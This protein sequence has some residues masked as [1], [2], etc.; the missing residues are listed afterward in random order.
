MSHYTTELRFVCETAANQ[1]ASGGYDDID[2]IIAAARTNIFSFNYPIFDAAYRET[3]ET[4]ILRRYYFREI[5]FETVGL[6]RHYLQMRMNEIMPYYN[7]LYS[8]ELLTFNP[9]YDTDLQTTGDKNSAGTSRKD[10][11]NNGTVSDSMTGNVTDTDSTRSTESRTSETQ[12]EGSEAVAAASGDKSSASDLESRNGSETV[13]AGKTANGTLT[14]SGTDSVDNTGTDTRTIERDDTNSHWDLYSDT[15]Q[16]G[17]DGVQSESTPYLTNARHV[18]DDSTGSETTDTLVHG[19]STDTI[20][21]HVETTVNRENESSAASKQEENRT[22]RES[23][24]EHTESTSRQNSVSE[25]STE[26]NAANSDTQHIKGYDTT[27]AR[28]ST[29]TSSE[30]GSTA[31]QSDY[32]EHVLGKSAGSGSYSKLLREFRETF[33]NIDMMVIDDLSDLFMQ[34]W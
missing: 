29:G 3:L 1:T 4:K 33:L 21:G 12:T 31:E 20:Y 8:S 26:E 23:E 14:H 18:I 7:K 6:F 2:S 34:V 28:T 22:D 5:G 11:S 10:G 27:N 15:P 13:N 30:V 24:T 16:G 19:L 17:L 9:L 25:S 32:A